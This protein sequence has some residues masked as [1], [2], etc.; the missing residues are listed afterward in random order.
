MELELLQNVVDMVL[1]RLDLDPQLD[2]DLFI[3]VFFL[4]QREDLAFPRGEMWQ[5]RVLHRPPCMSTLR[6]S[7]EEQCDDLRRTRG[8]SGHYSPNG[9]KQLLQGSFP[10]ELTCPQ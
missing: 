6:N 1:D 8:L 4:N 5:T 2:G 3:T 7:G 9:L 10:L